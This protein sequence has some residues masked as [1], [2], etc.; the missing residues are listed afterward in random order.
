MLDTIRTST[1]VAPELRVCSLADNQPAHTYFPRRRGRGAAHRRTVVTLRAL[2]RPDE[3]QGGV[4]GKGNKSACASAP[5]A[6]TTPQWARTF[7][8]I[9]EGRAKTGKGLLRR[10]GYTPRVDPDVNGSF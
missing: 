2:C 8:T 7:F 3:P 6:S 1:W 10:P 5:D 4:I 9:N